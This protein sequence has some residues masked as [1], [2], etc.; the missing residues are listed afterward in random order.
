MTAI[1]LRCQVVLQLFYLLPV[2]LQ[3]HLKLLY[4]ATEITNKEN[5]FKFCPSNEVMKFEICK[6]V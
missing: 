2:L 3:L 5:T 4:E 6:T 1:A